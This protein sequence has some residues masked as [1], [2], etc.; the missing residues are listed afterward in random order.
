MKKT[1]TNV[2]NK[3]LLLSFMLSSAVNGFSQSG[4]GTQEY[5]RKIL[6]WAMPIA[7]IIVAGLLLYGLVKN[8]RKLTTEDA[9]RSTAWRNIGMLFFGAIL[10]VVF[11]IVIK[12]W[13]I[14][15]EIDS[16]G[17]TSY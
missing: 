17:L 6:N 15:T 13:G 9:D 16:S 2:R 1:L 5:L 14:T 7:N 10:W 4:T 8:I 3:A 11:W 12:D